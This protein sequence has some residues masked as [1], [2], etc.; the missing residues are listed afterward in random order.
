MNTP[1]GTEE[2]QFKSFNGYLQLLI[3]L[4]ALVAIPLHIYFSVRDGSGDPNAFVIIGLALLF[5]FIVKGVYMLQ[6]NQSALLMLFGDVPRHGL[7]HG[8]AL[9]ESV[10]EQDRRSVCA[11]ATSTARSSR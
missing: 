7:L 8:P 4:A 10:H 5:V 6:P 3:A 1:G 2:V 9:G 11:C